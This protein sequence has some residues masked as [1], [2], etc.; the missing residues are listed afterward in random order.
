MRVKG[1]HQKW[2]GNEIAVWLYVGT[3]LTT[4][5]AGPTKYTLKEFNRLR[6]ANQELTWEALT[7]RAD[8]RLRD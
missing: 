7:D 6:E 4:I 1:Y 3:G 5:M 8:I 2:S